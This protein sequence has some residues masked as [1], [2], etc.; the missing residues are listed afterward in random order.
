M[1]DAGADRSTDD[2]GAA[3]GP[4]TDGMGGAGGGTGASLLAA[5]CRTD[6]DCDGLTCMTSGENDA[7]LGAG[8]GNGYCSMPCTD[9][10]DCTQVEANAIC[11]KRTPTAEVGRCLLG[12][13]RGGTSSI[14]DPLPAT[15]CRGRQD[16]GCLQLQGGATACY[17]R[18]G[19]D[20]DCAAPRVCSPRSGLCTATPP[21][22][23]PA[24]AP[25][26]PTQ[27]D[28][29]VG[30]C[31]A[32]TIAQPDGGS[33]RFGMCTSG[34]VMGNAGTSTQCG[35]QELGVCGLSGDGANGD[36]AFCMAPC[37]THG[38]C[39]AEEGMYCNTLARITDERGYCFRPGPCTTLGGQCAISDQRCTETPIGRV[40]F[41]SSRGPVPWSDAGAPDAA[42]DALP[43]AAAGDAGPQD[44]A[45]DGPSD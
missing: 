4:G 35:G 44:A 29:C 45:S 25:C 16:V 32:F 10:A 2:A 27:P 1:K 3:D 31:V 20:A 6:T 17:P 36:Y 19:D 18:C 14:Y 11:L 30:Q 40:C 21:T 43:E 8:V 15:K 5:A 23:L 22:G 41:D 33:Q 24:G 12:C 7:V 13:T 42:P 26:D 34:C 28:P 9:D 39:L 38:D 37:A